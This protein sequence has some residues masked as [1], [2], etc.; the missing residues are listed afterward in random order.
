MWSKI[1]ALNCSFK[2]NLSYF[3]QFWK[4]TTCTLYSNGFYTACVIDLDRLKSNGSVK[5]YKLYIKWKIWKIAFIHCPL[6]CLLKGMLQIDVGLKNPKPCNY[7]PLS[8]D[9]AEVEYELLR[10]TINYANTFLQFRQFFISHQTSYTSCTFYTGN[11]IRH[12]RRYK[13]VQIY[14]GS[15]DLVVG[16][17]Y[18]HLS[19]CS[20]VGLPVIE[21]YISISE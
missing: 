5:Q 3:C 18:S 16:L 19:L 8:F 15:R 9:S 2:R 21:L 14:R 7:P 17:R 12:R 4:K 11:I 20:D 1:I 13:N 10:A 6:E